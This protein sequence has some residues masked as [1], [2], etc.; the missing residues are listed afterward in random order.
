M[1]TQPYKHAG[2]GEQGDTSPDLLTMLLQQQTVIGVDSNSTT[3]IDELHIEYNL[4]RQEILHN[5]TL[6]LQVLGAAL[7]FIGTTITLAFSERITEPSV[8]GLLLIFAAAIALIGMSQGI[9]RAR[10]SFLIASYLRIFVEPELPALRWET[11]LAEYR[12][13]TP[14]V[15]FGKFINYQMWVYTALAIICLTFATLY[16]LSDTSQT[17]IPLY[18]RMILVTCSAIGT[19]WFL[20]LSWRRFSR[21]VIHH[22]E[23][24]DPIW[25]AI[26]QEEKQKKQK[27]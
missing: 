22:R 18:P 19:L 7:V 10:G 20:A 5:D 2:Q 15:G 21:F 11:R 17:I 8:R 25:R 6:I 12:Q 9:D 14:R 27:L 26:L 23:T 24:F 3:R 4:L 1:Q 16:I 13:R